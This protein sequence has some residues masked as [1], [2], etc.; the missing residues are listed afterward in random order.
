MSLTLT[1]QV[2]EECRNLPSTGL[3]ILD[4]ASIAEEFADLFPQAA[5]A[6]L[7]TCTE[8]LQQRL[9]APEHFIQFATEHCT[10]PARSG[11]AFRLLARLKKEE[12][13]RDAHCALDVT[14]SKVTDVKL[15]KGK[16]CEE[17]INCESASPPRPDSLCSNCG[18]EPCLDRQPVMDTGKVTP[19][20]QLRT[21]QGDDLATVV[22]IHP[23]GYNSRPLR[24]EVAG[25]LR[26][27]KLETKPRHAKFN[28]HCGS[29]NTES[30]PI[31][32]PAASK[33][34]K[35]SQY[36]P[37]PFSCTNCRQSP[38]LH[39]KPVLDTRKVPVGCR[40]LSASAGYFQG[41]DP[42][43]A[44]VVAVDQLGC[45]NPLRVAWP[46]GCPAKKGPSNYRE[47][48]EQNCP[49]PTK[50]KHTPTFTYFCT[51]E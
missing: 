47:R 23:E 10:D 33:P 5:E 4:A 9:T 35:G 49:L 7:E 25:I 19:G 8:E 15:R 29:T 43:L 12:G 42:M 27:Y 18:Q 2:V 31:T 51:G 44:T 36:P 45:P 24:V 1:S 22:K 46:K 40:L 6:V 39:N 11:T 48:S 20:C 28:Y 32:R 34:S 26:N 30:A 21:V 13:P 38:C 14:P 50:T 3:E 16:K 41:A 37:A 17:I